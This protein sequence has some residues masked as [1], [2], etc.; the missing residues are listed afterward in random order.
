MYG[1]VTPT[2]SFITDCAAPADK[3][4]AGHRCQDLARRVLSHPPEEVN[5]YVTLRDEVPRPRPRF[6]D[7]AR[8]CQKE[9]REGRMVFACRVGS[10]LVVLTPREGAPDAEA[11]TALLRERGVSGQGEAG[12]CVV[13]NKPRRCQRYD[14]PEGGQ[15]VVAP[16]EESPRSSPEGRPGVPLRGC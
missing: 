2:G 15:L 8:T 6:D 11:L 1:R 10:G 16:L 13:M 9:E 5:R 7:Q 12:L 3:P 4:D 14:V